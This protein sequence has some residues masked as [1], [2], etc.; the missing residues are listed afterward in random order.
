MN[1]K[2][3][4]LKE[5]SR[6]QYRVSGKDYFGDRKL[7]ETSIAYFDTWWDI[8]NHVIVSTGQKNIN[9]IFRLFLNKVQELDNSKEN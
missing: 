3:K 6:V 7:T 4:G 9:E 1:L 8:E 5:P 2:D